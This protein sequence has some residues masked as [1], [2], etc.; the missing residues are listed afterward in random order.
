MA[1][2][3]RA[4]ACRIPW[5]EEAGGLQSMGLERGGHE[6]VTN[7]FTFTSMVQTV[8]SAHNTG[9]PGLIPQLG[10]SSGEGNGNPF[11][12]PSLDNTMDR[13]A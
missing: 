12:Y 11:Q 2:H 13:G 4:L 8:E 5:T 3:S 10:R 7:T 9:D 6:R 1:T